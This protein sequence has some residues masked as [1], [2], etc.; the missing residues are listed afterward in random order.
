M[1]DLITQSQIWTFLLEEIKRRNIG[2]IA[3]SH[4]SELMKLVCTK[5]INL[6]TG[7]VIEKAIEG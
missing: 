5:Q 3:V 2:F 4:N 7:E 6:V 1:L